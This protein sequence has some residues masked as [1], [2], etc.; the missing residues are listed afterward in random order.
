[1]RMI[2]KDDKQERDEDEN[3]MKNILP[4]TNIQ[5]KFEM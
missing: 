4:S 1:M 3:G 2:N 5:K